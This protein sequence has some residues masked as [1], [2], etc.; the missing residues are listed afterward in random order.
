VNFLFIHESKYHVNIYLNT[1]LWVSILHVS[2][3]YLREFADKFV[4]VA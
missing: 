3:S 4:L 1:I 2:W